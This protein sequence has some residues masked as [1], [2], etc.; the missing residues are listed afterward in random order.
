[1]Y[2]LACI[3]SVDLKCDLG[4]FSTSLFN[5][6]VPQRLMP[7]FFEFI[8]LILWVDAPILLVHALILEFMLVY[9][10]FTPLYFE[11]NNTT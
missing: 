3:T 6:M 5:Y 1:M 11:I 10:E 4:T 9:F 8:I 7:L 2:M